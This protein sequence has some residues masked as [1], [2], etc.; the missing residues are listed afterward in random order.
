MKDQATNPSGA[1]SRRQFIKNSS[2]AAAGAS[3]LAS[4]GCAAPSG[5]SESKAPAVIRLRSTQ[6]IRAVVIGVGGRGSG[7]GRDFLDAVKLLG[8]DGK[9]VATADVYAEQAR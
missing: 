5:R 2:L 4:S 6:P 9:I 1:V 7:A 8:I 3:L